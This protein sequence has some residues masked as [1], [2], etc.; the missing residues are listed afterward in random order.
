MLKSLSACPIIVFSDAVP[1]IYPIQCGRAVSADRELA[2]SFYVTVEL[3]QKWEG[4]A[5]L[6]EYGCQIRT[7]KT[8]RCDSSYHMP[9]LSAYQTISRAWSVGPRCVSKHSHQSS[10]RET[11]EATA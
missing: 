2:R 1:V 10:N 3:D 6:D 8:Q 11:I 7:R 9:V 5:K 4:E